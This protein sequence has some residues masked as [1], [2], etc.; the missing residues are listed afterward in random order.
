MG[1]I[2]EFVLRRG[3]RIAKKLFANRTYNSSIFNDK[4]TPNTRFFVVNDGG[5]FLF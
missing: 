1:H 3:K 5:V 4:R 2:L